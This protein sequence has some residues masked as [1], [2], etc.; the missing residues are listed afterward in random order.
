MDLRSVGDEVQDDALGLRRVARAQDGEAV[1]FEGGGG[2]LNPV[3]SAR[4]GETTAI[5]R[6]RLGGV[7]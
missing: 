4:R 2:P 1:R 3:S 6:C 5:G 7:W